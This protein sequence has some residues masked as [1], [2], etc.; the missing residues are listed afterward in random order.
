MKPVFR[1]LFGIAMLPLALVGAV[2]AH[3]DSRFFAE[4]PGKH[5]EDQLDGLAERGY[6]NVGT[7]K[8][9]SSTIYYFW[10]ERIEDCEVLTA[11]DGRVQNV[12]AVS[13]SVCRGMGGGNAHGGGRSRDRDEYDSGP[14]SREIT[15]LVGNKRDDAEGKLARQG[16]QKVE[17]DKAHGRTSSLWWNRSR[18]ECISVESKDGRVHNIKRESRSSC[19]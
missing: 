1:S 8:E 5:V 14:L 9:H 17:G 12:S 18:G 11:R 6:R 3:A 16:F 2:S 13:A 7:E 15:G 19:D 4:L 10:N